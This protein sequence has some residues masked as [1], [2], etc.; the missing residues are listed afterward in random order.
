VV[1]STCEAEIQVLAKTAPFAVL[2]F[3][4]YSV[5]YR[6]VLGCSA[7]TTEAGGIPSLH[8]GIAFDELSI[9]LV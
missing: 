1:L 3:E 4:S 6:T 5:I 9:S 7:S 2:S 8:E